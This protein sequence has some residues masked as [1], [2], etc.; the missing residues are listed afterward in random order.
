MSFFDQAF[1]IVVGIEAGYVN[2]VNDPGGETKYGISKRAYPNVD[3]PQLTLDEARA[4]YQRD[5][6]NACGCDGYSWEVALVTFDCAVNQGV[7]AA[8]ALHAASTDAADFQALR[9]LRYAKNPN[10]DRF[11]KGWMRRLFTVFKQAQRT[12]T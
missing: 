10:F 2:D 5:Y 1:A 8:Q 3:I 4:I 7:G 11:G 9:A 6:W 12:P